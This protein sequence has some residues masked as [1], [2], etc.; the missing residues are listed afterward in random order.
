MDSV[1]VDGMRFF[2]SPQLHSIMRMGKKGDAV[3]IEKQLLDADYGLPGKFIT[4]GYYA[5]KIFFFPLY[6][7]TVYVYDLRQK[8]IENI[9][10]EVNTKLGYS[11]FSSAIVGNKI[12]GIPG[13]YSRFIIIDGTN[14]VKEEIEFDTKKLNEVEVNKSVYFTRCNYVYDNTLFVGS[15]MSNYIISISLDNYRVEYYELELCNEEKKGVY[16]LCGNGC[17]LYVLGNDGK[18][19]IYE[20]LKKRMSLKRVISMSYI[21]LKDGSY[22]N[23][24][25]LNGK[26]IMFSNDGIIT[27]DISKEKIMKKSIDKKNIVCSNISSI[28]FFYAYKFDNVI[29]AMSAMDF[30]EY[31]FDEDIKIVGEKKYCIENN[32]LTKLELYSITVEQKEV[33]TRNLNYFINRLKCE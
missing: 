24:L 17:E 30:V 7:Q 9:Q 25:Y 23:S 27:C 2:Y 21:A 8:S 29:R 26:F 1:E 31:S 6:G 18:L 11:I 32:E 20:C 19:R 15:L 14:N 28:G 22:A 4:L 10:L 5:Y 3:E 33:Y 13:R 16:T 12:I